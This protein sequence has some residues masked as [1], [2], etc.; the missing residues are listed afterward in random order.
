MATPRSCKS[1]SRTAAKSRS[2]WGK[3]TYEAL[4]LYLSKAEEMNYDQVL[5]TLADEREN[6]PTFGDAWSAAERQVR[7]L[8]EDGKRMGLTAEHCTALKCYTLQEPNISG[9]FNTACLKARRT[10]ASWEGFRFKSLWC[11]LVDAFKRLPEFD[12]DVPG[13]FYRGTT[14][15]MKVD[16]TFVC[17]SK[18]LSASPL[19]EE[20]LKFTKGR[21]EET[22][23]TIESVPSEYVRDISKFSI[24]PHHREVLIWPLCVF[25]CSDEEETKAE[26]R[27][28]RFKFLEAE[29]IREPVPLQSVLKAEDTAAG[30]DSK[31]PLEENT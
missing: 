8:Y 25:E 21:N 5:S 18:F 23:M 3:A 1:T 12:D 19:F 27:G 6:N 28:Q 22:V 17:F 11:L 20:A 31:E 30:H 26:K 7:G 29:P 24:Y 2:K 9:A 13:H 4:L 10:E 15:P 16:P 14:G